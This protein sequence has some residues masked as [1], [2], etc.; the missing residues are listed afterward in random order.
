MKGL[1]V[2]AFPQQ[3]SGM[4]VTGLPVATQQETTIDIN[5][6]MNLML[7]MMVIV[8]IMKMMTKATESIR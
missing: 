6:I 8:M 7:M 2:G 5:T 4:Q 3:V 1:T